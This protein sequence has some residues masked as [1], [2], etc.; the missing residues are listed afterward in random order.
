M[1]LY[2]G[3]LFLRRAVPESH[4]PILYRQSDHNGFCC[5]ND[6]PAL[7]CY[8]PVLLE[9]GLFQYCLG[10]EFRLDGHV[11]S[12]F[13]GVKHAYLVGT[14]VSLTINRYTVGCH[15]EGNLLYHFKVRDD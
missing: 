12:I 4:Y 5:D 2:S 6:I 11:D 9:E 10:G 13:G 3:P 14:L 15:S 7:P 8:L 1:D